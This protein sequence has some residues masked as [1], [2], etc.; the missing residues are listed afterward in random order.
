MNHM[1][2]GTIQSVPATMT[3]SYIVNI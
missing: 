1:I 2:N 3:R